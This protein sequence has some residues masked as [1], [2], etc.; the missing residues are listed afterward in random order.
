[1]PENDK[2][3]TLYGVYNTLYS[4]TTRPDFK[5]AVTRYFIDEWVPL[6]G[7]SLAWLVVG[8]RQHCYWNQ[9]RNWCII[10]KAGLA[11][12]TA[13]NERTI[14][15]CLKKPFSNW[16]IMEIARRY[17]Y[18]VQIGK[19]VRDK[20]RYQ[21]LLDE[22]LSPRHQ[23]GLLALL[24]KA[25]YISKTAEDSKTSDI[26]DK[27]LAAVQ[28]LLETPDLTDKISY[29][30]KLPNQLQRRT[31]LEL[32]E[33][34]FKFKLSDY[35][36]DPRVVKLDQYCTQLYNQIV[37][38]NKIYVGWQ[39]FRLEWVGRLGHA[40]AWLVIYMRRHCFWDDASGELRDIFSAYKKEIA[41]AIG[42]TVRNLANLMEHPQAGLFFTPLDPPDR[43]QNGRSGPSRYQVRLVDEP[44][45]PDDQ[46]RVAAELSRR[47]QEEQYGQNPETGQFDLFPIFDRLSTRQNF[48]YGQA[49][50]EMPVSEQKNRRIEAEPVEKMAQHAPLTAGK[51]AATLKD[52][53]IIPSSLDKKQKEQRHSVAELNKLKLLFEDLSI[54]EPARSK[55]LA[56][57]NL[58]VADVGA[59]V[60]YAETQPA[61]RDF[62]SYVIKRLLAGDPPPT[63]FLSFARL[64]DATWDIFEQATAQLRTGQRLTVEIASS[65]LDTFINWADIY[66]GLTPPETRYLLARQSMTLATGLDPDAP[67]V[68]E[69]EPD[70][71]ERELA[72]SLW[73]TALDQL[74]LQMTQQSFNNWLRQTELLD[75]HE[76]TFVIDAKNS[77]AKA[78]LENRLTETIEKTLTSVVGAPTHVRFVVE[79]ERI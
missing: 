10:D 58:T 27:A 55:L 38:P 47:L 11:R 34:A 1:M 60:L 78:W 8:L 7:P 74:R 66:G 44:L 40:L 39:Y 68:D 54:Q 13:L 16:F 41:A 51:N 42:Q 70:R 73:L 53:L 63:E 35:A 28:R 18:R 62:R 33:E 69:F 72:R 37:Q 48:A 67:E 3:L 50:E 52:S 57:P 24:A 15:R 31:I 6:L 59:W 5:F 26:L 30:G 45:T 12:D 23:L 32:V 2:T 65:L 71:Q 77:H 22:P 76:N 9:R 46:Q 75:Y 21:L 19:K 36:T 49:A 25:I 64:D 43:S 20:N 79:N 56:N 17:R 4:A 29:T 14:E 61:L